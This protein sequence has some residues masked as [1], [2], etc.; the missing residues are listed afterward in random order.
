MKPAPIPSNETQRLRA[1]HMAQVLDTPADSRFDRI[2]RTAR[3]MFNVPIALVS[4]VDSQRQWFLSRQGLDAT[5]TPRNV[6]FCGH[7]IMAERL[8]VVEDS[9]LDPRFRD[10]PLV[11]GPP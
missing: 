1:L 3:R 8:F 2:T 11:T 6:S 10:N 4:L 9:N 5:E 7:A